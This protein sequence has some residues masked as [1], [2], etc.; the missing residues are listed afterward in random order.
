VGLRHQF[1]LSQAQDLTVDGEL[2]R[3]RPPGVGRVTW[4]GVGPV[5]LWDSRQGLFWPTAGSLLRIDATFFRPAFGADFSAELVRMDL[6]H[7]QSVWWSHVLALRLI[8]YG[9]TGELPFQLYPALGGALLFRG[10]F[11]GRLRDRVLLASEAEYRIPLTLR[12]A[13]V[14][15]GSVGRVAERVSALSPLGLKLAGGAGVRF[16]VRPESRAN[17]R[18]DLAYGDE[19]YVY[20]QFREAF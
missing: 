11:L 20:F 14:G 15:F 2:A 18:L 13:L 3:T 4:S 6:R 17:F 7:Y 9:A 8:T 12:W 16:A 19:L 5:L 10:W 1:R